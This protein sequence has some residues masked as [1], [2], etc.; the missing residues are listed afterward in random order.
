MAKFPKI[1]EM[2]KVYPEQNRRAFT[3]IEMVV[4][5]AIVAMLSVTAVVSLGPAQQSVSAKTGADEVKTLLEELR[6]YAV[7]PAQERAANYILI[8]RTTTGPA[9]HYCNAGLSSNPNHLTKNSYMF[10]YTNNKNI[11]AATDLNTGFSRVRGGSFQAQINLTDLTG[12][13][14]PSAGILV[15]NARTYDTQLGYNRRYFDSGATG[16]EE[17]QVT[18]IKN[19]FSKRITVDPIL[20]LIT[21]Q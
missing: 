18:D 10:C 14:S 2:K 9:G 20:N 19:T 3:L 17:I 13:A 15:F 8:I 4:S 5:V 1:G 21:L 6:S 12:L 11:T 7:G 16:N